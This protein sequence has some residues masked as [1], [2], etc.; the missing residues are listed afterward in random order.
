TRGNIPMKSRVTL[1]VAACAVCWSM[2]PGLAIAQV[3]SGTANVNLNA[4]MAQSLSINITSGST[5][6]FT[7]V[8]GGVATGSNPV[9][10]STSWNLSP[11]LVGAVSLY[12]YFSTPAQALTD[13][14]GNNI[15]STMVQGRMTTGIPA[16]Y[17]PFTLTSPVG[18]AGGSLVLFTEVVTALNAVKTR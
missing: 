5:V 14:A 15:T 10:V 16:T 17:V 18:P 7:L 3:L 4:A 11:L 8:N 1:L 9:V 6:N 13:G 2:A 12:G